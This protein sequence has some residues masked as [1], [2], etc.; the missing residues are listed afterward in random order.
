MRESKRSGRC[1]EYLRVPCRCKEYPGMKIAD[2]ELIDMAATCSNRGLRLNAEI[3]LRQR[4]TLRRRATIA[5]SPAP[6]SEEKEKA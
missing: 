4:W 1:L 6:R 5:A 3:V 2:D